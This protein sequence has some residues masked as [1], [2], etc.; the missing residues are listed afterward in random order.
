MQQVHSSNGYQCPHSFEIAFNLPISDCTRECFSISRRPNTRQIQGLQAD[1]AD[2]CNCP[3]SH[4]CSVT[5]H[6][7]YQFETDTIM[8][9]A[10]HTFRSIMIA[11]VSNTRQSRHQSIFSFNMCYNLTKQ[12]PHNILFFGVTSD[13]QFIV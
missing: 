5:F 11:Q 8:I 10:I 7:T 4:T 13:G 2:N 3:C 1:T 9:D 12:T 6:F